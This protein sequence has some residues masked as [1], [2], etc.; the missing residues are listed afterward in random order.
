MQSSCRNSAHRSGATRW[1]HPTRVPRV[2]P[3]AC[4]SPPRKSGLAANRRN[5]D[6][7]N[8]GLSAPRDPSGRIPFRRLCRRCRSSRKSP[9]PPCCRGRRL[10]TNTKPSRGRACRSPSRDS[11]RRA[12]EDSRSFDRAGS[13]SRSRSRRNAHTP[14]PRP[15]RRAM[16]RKAAKRQRQFVKSTPDCFS[17]AKL[18]VG[19]GTSRFDS[20]QS[21]RC[22]SGK[23]KRMFG[24]CSLRGPGVWQA[25]RTAAVAVVLRKRRRV[26]ADS[27][28]SISEPSL[29]RRCSNGKAHGDARTALRPCVSL[30]RDGDVKLVEQRFQVLRQI[31]GA[32]FLKRLTRRFHVHVRFEARTGC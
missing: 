18:G 13:S 22:W 23:K 1:N 26:D 6:R 3:G 31:G 17:F 14:V 4:E 8:R 7:R 30:R 32:V 15:G 20:T 28:F 2:S 24:R 12:T 27:E 19:T 29:A 10:P 25:P 11:R 9:K 5:P 16:A 21:G